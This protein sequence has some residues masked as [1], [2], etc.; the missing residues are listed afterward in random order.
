MRIDRIDISG[1]HGRATVFRAG[2]DIVINVTRLRDRPTATVRRGIGRDDSWL[3]PAGA[4][5]AGQRQVAAQ[6]L[7]TAL[8]GAHGTHGDVADYL[9]VIETFAD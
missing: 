1:T 5:R 4:D 6:R 3:V 2:S 8:E 9:R 7:Q